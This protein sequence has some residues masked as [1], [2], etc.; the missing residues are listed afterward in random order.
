MDDLIKYYNE[1]L[2]YLRH[3][4]ELFSNK[5]PEIA[6]KLRLNANE[7]TDP[8]VA[9]ITESFA[10]VTARIKQ[11]LD[12]G[13]AEIN[14]ALLDIILPHL[15][16]PLPSF[17]IL[18]F[19]SKSSNKTVHA[20]TKGTCLNFKLENKANYEFITLYNT[21]ILPLKINSLKFENSPFSQ[22]E[23]I[24]KSQAKSRL[25]IELST[26]NKE[27]NF[28][29]LTNTTIRFFISLELE[30]AYQLYT[31]IFNHLEAI[32]LYYPENPSQEINLALS[33]IQE[34]GFKNHE[35]ALAFNKNSFQGYRL[36]TEFFAYPQKFLF[37][38]LD[39]PSH[40][41]QLLRNTLN[42]HLYFNIHNTNLAKTVNNGALSLNCVPI[43]NIY[44]NQA[45]VIKLD[46]SQFEYSVIPKNLRNNTAQEVYSISQASTTREQQPFTIHPYF[47]L[48]HSALQEQNLYW[49]TRRRSSSENNDLNGIN[50]NL[51]ISF[52]HLDT[53]PLHKE[54]HI[55]NLDLLCINYDLY[56]KL[57]IQNL[58]YQIEFKENSYSFVKEMFNIIPVTDLQRPL[59]GYKQHW[60]IFSHLLLNASS[61]L[62]SENESL[63]DLK[64]LLTIYN[65]SEN[66]Y[67]QSLINCLE[68][69]QVQYS[70]SRL[71]I[72]GKY[73][74]CNGVKV[75]IS[76]NDAY[77]KYSG[78][79][80]FGCILRKFLGLYVSINNFIDFK[81]TDK[82][83]T[84]IYQWQ[85]LL[86]QQQ[87]F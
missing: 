63:T 11:K 4:G 35:N 52:T 28:I 8:F 22:I 33:C 18:Q 70:I 36:I 78:L 59:L 10:F 69:V 66:T 74:F 30:N 7:I 58:D 12:D 81:M 9:Q 16:R 50:N 51:Q 77:K 87:A 1:E 31:L 37:F 3:A 67:N 46:H 29:Q 82:T 62:D 24:K 5:N 68:K 79:F 14:E 85:P 48:K 49:H 83:G 17:S 80:L 53:L 21:P 40:I 61:L 72:A 44:E 57:Y 71:P 39:L 25:A 56:Q 47:G 32:S 64:E 34:I 15:T 6:S 19:C 65:T 55:V 75:N 84:I 73:G 2:N 26:H 42:I 43:I 45:E 23:N 38:D 13:Y 76:L 60:K 54:Q 41:L 86:G 27:L 20:I